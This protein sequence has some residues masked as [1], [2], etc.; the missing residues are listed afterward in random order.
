V[1]RQ[2]KINKP[3]CELDENGNPKLVNV[4]DENGDVVTKPAYQIR[5]LK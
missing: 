1:K 3:V 2:V 4:V 5:Y